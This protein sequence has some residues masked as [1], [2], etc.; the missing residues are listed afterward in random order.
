MIKDYYTILEVPPN[1]GL[2]EIRKAYRRLALIYHPDKNLDDQNKAAQ[3]NDIKEAYEVLTNPAKKELYLQQRWYNQSIGRKRAWETVTPVFVLRLSLELEKYVS[4]LDVYRMNTE[5]LSDYVLELLSMDTIEKLNQ[6]NEKEINRQVISSILTAITP[7]P[8]KFIKPISGSL[9]IIA[10]NDEGSLQ[11][12]N[13]SLLDHKR[14]FLW[15]KYKIVLVLLFTI[16]V[17]LLIY[18]TSR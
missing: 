6:F 15:D 2:P 14:K 9:K 16:L 8:L 3:F 5:G 17:C 7:L 13:E 1:A 11:K 18:F 10:G 12:I 4:T